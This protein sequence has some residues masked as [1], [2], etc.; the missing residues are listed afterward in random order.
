LYSSCEPLLS[1]TVE[2]SGSSTVANDPAGAVTV[3]GMLR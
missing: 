3:I 1:S 2:P